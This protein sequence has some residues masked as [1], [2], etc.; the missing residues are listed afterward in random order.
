MSIWERFFSP[1]FL[2]LGALVALTTAFSVARADAPLFPFSAEGSGLSRIWT[3]PMAN[4]ADKASETENAAENAN[5]TNVAETNATL[6]VI[7]GATAG[8]TGVPRA[9]G[10]I[11]VDDSGKRLR[12]WGTN[13]PFKSNFPEKEDATA[14]AKRL[15]SFGFNCV[16]LHFLDTEIWG[17]YRNQLGCRKMDE[18]ELDRLDWFIFQLKK[19]GIF[20]NMN[21]HVGR[22]LDERDGNFPDAERLPNMQKG[23]GS[24]L[25]EM[26]ELEKE[27]ARDLLTH[28]NP[29]LGKS[30]LEDPCVAFIEINNENSILCE[31]NCGHLDDLPEFYAE[32]LQSRWNAWL[33]KRYASTEELRAA[34]H[35]VNEPFGEELIPDCEFS[36]AESLGKFPWRL[37]QGRDSKAETSVDEAAGLLRIDVKKSAAGWDPQFYLTKNSVKKGTP[38]LVEFRIRSTVPKYLIFYFMENHP[39]WQSE[40][41]WF[42]IGKEWKTIKTTVRPDFTDS[43][44]RFGFAG[45]EGVVEIDR[46][47][48]RSG[49]TLGLG[50]GESLE[51]GNISF[52]RWNE[53]SATYEQKQ[54]F[55]EFLLDL[56]REYWQTMF[57]WIK[58]ELKPR[59]P[60]AGTQLRYASTYA[61]A[62][63]DYCDVHDY[64]C[65]P[66]W[67]NRPWDLS[68][69]YVR[70]RNLVDR[71]AFERTFLGLANHRVAG[72]PFVL[73]EFNQPYPNFY[74]AEGFAVVASLGAFQNWSG[75][76]SYCWSHNRKHRNVFPFFEL[77]ENPTI[78]VHHP[79][80]V[81]LFVRGDMK[82]ATE[83]PE[84]PM[85]VLEMTKAE[86]WAFLRKNLG[87]YHRDL[88]PF[89]GMKSSDAFQAYCAL[90]LPDLNIPVPLVDSVPALNRSSD[91]NVAE[92]RLGP[93]NAQKRIDS[94]TGEIRWNG[95]DSGKA[96]FLVDTPRTKLFTGKI[97]GRTFAF[98]DG[99]RLTP[100]ETRLDWATVSL[101]QATETSWLLA[102][103]GLEKNSGGRFRP[104]DQPE[105]TDGEDLRRLDD[106]K[107]FSPILGET[108]RLCEGIPI[109]L[110]LPVSAS[111]TVAISPLDGN[112]QK[113]ESDVCSV[114]RISDSEVEILISPET[115]TLWYLLEILP[116]EKQ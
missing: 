49:G 50:A 20:V 66:E 82:S 24:F 87:G 32:K 104:Y 23:V 85:A 101:T 113:M 84:P 34:W 88:A 114:R 35:S 74:S 36:S 51:A 106:S 75:I 112:A 47:S 17:K 55:Q 14:L 13:L 107:L 8:E 95:E 110:V 91:W 7:A 96:Y 30:Y 54:D 71:L 37:E 77:C 44:V 19:N 56:D 45:L 94:P 79:A 116:L 1:L 62:E 60:I 6:N 100:G 48:V 109:S 78:L 65:H 83:L 111:K 80:F 81:N 67:P 64:W 89:L 97:A 69:W 98:K 105:W 68:D 5:A 72:K 41:K 59:A 103:T 21:L 12:F 76:Y 58:D 4:A 93:E 92:R 28:V 31:W 70:N 25:P 61:Q 22:I 9:V 73:S 46:F 11:F 86:E 3:P 108:P 53:L 52:V 33:R 42:P 10:D 39:D 102:A 38:Y 2:P 15:R 57:R 43:D 115:K 63:M 99:L 16:R 90:R 40:K 18:E 29:Y 26:V 27:Y